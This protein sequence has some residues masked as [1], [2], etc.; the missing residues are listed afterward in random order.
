MNI[1]GI[2]SLFGIK[3]CQ[4]LVLWKING[5]QVFMVG[6]DQSVVPTCGSGEK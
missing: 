2:V 5:V 6:K 4:L 3:K 1:K